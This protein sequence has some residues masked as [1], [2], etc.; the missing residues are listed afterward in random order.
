MKA[1]GK[2]IKRM[3]LVFIFIMQEGSTK[4]SGFMINSM[5]MGKKFGLMGL[6]IK[7]NS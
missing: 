5:D 3:V 4:V 6:N 1:N 2:R 7:E